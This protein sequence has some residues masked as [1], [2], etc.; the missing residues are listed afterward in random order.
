[1]T[2]W[3][4]VELGFQSIKQFI[5]AYIQNKSDLL[6]YSNYGYHENSMQRDNN[7]N[8]YLIHWNHR[9]KGIFMSNFI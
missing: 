9:V 1:V 5:L 8:K 7:E 3:Y 4:L 6:R 2:L